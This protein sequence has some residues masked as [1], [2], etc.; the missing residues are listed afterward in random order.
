MS[1][2]NY[3]ND[4]WFFG[5]PVTDDIMRNYLKEKKKSKIPVDD[6][7]VE[8]S[9]GEESSGEELTGEEY[10]PFHTVPDHFERAIRLQDSD[11]KSDP[12]KYPFKYLYHALVW[13]DHLQEDTEILVFQRKEPDHFPYS[14][15]DV[16]YIADILEVEEEPKWYFGRDTRYPGDPEMP[17]ELCKTREEVLE[18]RKARRQAEKG[19]GKRMGLTEEQW[20]TRFG[21]LIHRK[22]RQQTTGDD[23]EK[24]KGK[25][26][27][28]ESE[29]LTLD[30]LTLDTRKDVDVDE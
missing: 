4:Q 12:P 26:D 1:D 5:L 21:H 13:D 24:G 16:K 14:I 18:R 6:S 15:E 17:G 22:V 8:E 20:E 28:G 23:K 27:S 30:T 7:T 9:S 29:G 10:L 25:T 3:D 11:E 19:K 2:P